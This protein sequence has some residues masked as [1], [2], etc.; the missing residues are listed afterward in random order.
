MGIF[1]K[2]LVSV[3]DSKYSRD[4]ARLAAKIAKFHGSQV[5]LFHVLDALLVDK[6]KSLSKKDKASIREE[7]RHNAQGFLKDMESEIKKEKVSLEV[8]I[9]EGIPHE[10]I[11]TEASSW[12][13]NLIVMGKLGR[14]GISHI[15][16]GS[17]TER[18]IEFSDI[19]VL[20]VK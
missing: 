9:K 19:P 1:D 11:L 3:D 2:I 18:V 5:K 7:L 8:L 14:R 20:V 13:A 15:V 10:A 12:G 6:L 16:L 4:A 17:V